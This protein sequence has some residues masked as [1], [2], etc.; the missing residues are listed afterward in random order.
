MAHNKRTVAAYALKFGSHLLVPIS[1]LCAKFQIHKTK[2]VITTTRKRQGVIFAFLFRTRKKT[3]VELARDL[4]ATRLCGSAQ[5]PLSLE[6]TT[7]DRL[8]MPRMP[9]NQASKAIGPLS[10]LELRRLLLRSF[11]LKSR[12]GRANLSVQNGPLWHASFR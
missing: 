2:T 9:Q 1:R 8:A 12:R 11:R 10:S 5:A 4:T 3:L 6:N 7:L